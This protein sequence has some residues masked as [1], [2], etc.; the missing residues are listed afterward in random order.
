[1][2][3]CQDHPSFQPLF[4]EA[5]TTINGSSNILA[6][7]L[8]NTLSGITEIYD[9]GSKETKEEKTSTEAT[10]NTSDIFEAVLNDIATKNN[11]ATPGNEVV[12]NFIKEYP[13][14]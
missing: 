10:T 3:L 4:V 14:E 13:G 11:P 12:Q 8:V 1:L 7:D 6:P 5:I 9:L 2:K